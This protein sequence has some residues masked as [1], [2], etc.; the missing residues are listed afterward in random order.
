MG[1]GVMLVILERPILSFFNEPLLRFLFRR[2]PAGNTLLERRSWR[3]GDVSCKVR[4]KTHKFVDILLGQYRRSKF[5]KCG[6]C[7]SVHWF[8]HHQRVHIKVKE[9]L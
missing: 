3:A 2:L 7:S 6:E 4:A 5:F 1:R 8:Q 9:L